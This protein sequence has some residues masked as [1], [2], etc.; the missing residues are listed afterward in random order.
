[1]SHAPGKVE[2]YDSCG[3]LA[4]ALSLYHMG[5][6]GGTH[7]SHTQGWSSSKGDYFSILKLL[8]AYL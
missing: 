3:V 7:K 5:I 6:L 8:K 2:G 4:A 1:M